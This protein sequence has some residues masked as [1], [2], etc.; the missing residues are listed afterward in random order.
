[1]AETANRIAQNT[2]YLYLKMGITVFVSLYT[3]RIIL[4]SLGASDFGLF[5]IIGGSI[6]M[7]GFI[8][9]SMASATQRF[10]SFAEGEGKEEKKKIVFNVSIILHF[11]IALIAVLVFFIFSFYLFN[12]ILNIPDDRLYSGKIVYFCLIVSLFFTIQ[13]VPYDAVL[14]AHE[15]MRYFA[16]V[17]IVE[18]L[19]KLLVA[20][21]VCYSLCDKFVLYGI[22][23]AIIPIIM[24]TVM[25]IYCKNRY[26]ECL[27]SPRRF[28]DKP[29]MK[30]MTSFA[31]WNLQSTATAIISNYG[32]GVVLNHFYGTI[33]NAAQGVAN[34]VSG[35]LGA[36]GTSFKKAVN[37]VITKSAGG[38][39]FIRMTKASFTGCK[40]TYFVVTIT[41]IPVIVD[42]NYILDLWLIS[43]PENARLFCV[44]LLV[45]NIFQNL[46]VFVPTTIGAIGDI[47]RYSLVCSIKNIVP[48]VLTF[49]LFCIG[50]PPYFM[51]ISIIL[52]ALLGCVIDLY[53]GKIKFNLNVSLYVKN[54][55]FR[56]LM[57]TC[58]SFFA[59]IFVRSLMQEA[60]LRFLVIGLV[61]SL[62][63]ILVFY[64]FALDAEER[65]M[66]KDLV[67]MLREKSFSVL[68][69]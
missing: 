3:T 19:L 21:I 8:N 9:D 12:G 46:T 34:Q 22:L 41:F 13:T 11:V 64:L 62:I 58:I 28:W 38:S 31:L 1:M 4:N 55:I 25:R 54:V 10:I 61:T 51:Y 17:G 36:L 60:F 32:I 57:C 67:K 27:F 39:D 59:G 53:Y 40:I 69:R 30:E 29:T 52:T 35:Q 50:M 49:V 5:N 44:L 6:A 24:M 47:K 43:P 18:S 33:A 2:G 15:N 42:S 56:L 45:S 68:I 37:P 23:M 63:Y 20:E 66:S 16:L 14:N 7:L 48:I 65:R 26:P